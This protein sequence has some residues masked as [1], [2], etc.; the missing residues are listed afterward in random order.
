[1]VITILGMVTDI[2][3]KFIKDRQRA[4]IDAAKAMKHTKGG[5]RVPMTSKPAS[6]YQH[7][8][9]PCSVRSLSWPKRLRAGSYFPT[10]D[11]IIY[12]RKIGSIRVENRHPCQRRG[13]N[14]SS[15]SNPS[16]RPGTG[17]EKFSLA[18]ICLAISMAIGS[19]RPEPGELVAPRPN[20][21]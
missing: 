3:L 1:M 12:R 18:C 9:L 8:L 13:R 19:P 7:A 20:L 2:K 11:W 21:I 4:G 14:R 10:F 16:S 15:A 6:A 17:E 5:R